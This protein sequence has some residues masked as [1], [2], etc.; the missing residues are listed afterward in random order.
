MVDSVASISP[1]EEVLQMMVPGDSATIFINL[2]TVKSK[3]LGFE[4]ESWFFYDIVAVMIKEEAQ[5]IRDMEIERD[6]LDKERLVFQA[7]EKEVTANVKTIVK[8]YNRGKLKSKIKTT[9]S[10][11]RYIVYQVGKGPKL[12]QGDKVSVHYY[13]V[14]KNGKDFDNS[15]SRGVP[16]SFDLGEAM[17]I[18]GWDEGITLLNEGSKAILFIPHSLAYGDEGSPPLIPAKAELIFYVE[19]LE[20]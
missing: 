1:I 9:A 3:P 15:F 7:R 10:G 18:K 13:G 16:I 12:K 11:L 20:K 2:D 14:L 5:F 17:V 4:N 8:N 19:I 6:S